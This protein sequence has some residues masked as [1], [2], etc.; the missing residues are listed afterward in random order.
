MKFVH[1][2]DTFAQKNFYSKTSLKKNQYLILINKLI[3]LILISFKIK[4]ENSEDPKKR[5]KIKD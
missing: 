4:D 5:L 1:F 2:M 3:C